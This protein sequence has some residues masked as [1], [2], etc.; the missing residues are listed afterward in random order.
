M[1]WGEGWG[2]RIVREF[3]EVMYTLLYL[4]W[5]TNK[6]LQYSTDNPAQSHVV[7]WMGG[8]CG[9]LASEIVK[10]QKGELHAQN[11]DHGALFTIKMPRVKQ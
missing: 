4:K 6:D 11:T 5:I 8:V 10:L 9:A 2:E 7:A 3:G 1:G